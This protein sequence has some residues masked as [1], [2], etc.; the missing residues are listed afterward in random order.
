MLNR[1]YTA[2]CIVLAAQV[3]GQTDTT[4]VVQ[5]SVV[6]DTAN[7]VTTD[8][9]IT[10]TSAL[11]LLFEKLYLLENEKS[12]QVNIV[13]IGD[14]HIQAD[15]F[16]GMIRKN[17][18]EK[19]GNGGIG[20]SFPHTLAKTNGSYAVKYTSNTA[21]D[22]RRNIY[23]PEDGV[24]VGLSGI[25]LQTKQDF[26]I[27]VNVRDTANSFNTIKIISPDYSGFDLATTSKPIAIE[28]S[29]PKK[30]SHTIKRGEVLGTIAR[31]YGVTVAQIKNANGLRSDNIRAGQTLS[32][33]TGQMEKK[34]VQRSEFI[35]FPLEK[36]SLADYYVSTQPLS[37][38][39]ILPNRDYKNYSLNG[40]VLEKDKPG[41]LYHSIGVN[42]A[43]ASDY[44]KYPLFFKQLKAL[45]PDLIVISLGTNE[46]FDKMVVQDYMVQLNLFLDNIRQQNPDACVLVMTPPPSLFN[47]KYPNTFV[48]EYAK[49]IQM[50]ETERLYA[51]WDLFSEMGGLFN[52][53]K[54]AANGLM[55]ADKVH[56]SV[57]GYEKQG[58]LFY[59]AFIKA[60]ENFKT[61][62]E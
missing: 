28:S 14:S 8:N 56:Y 50:Q 57:Q 21:W 39:Y 23:A 40:L 38:I 29:V 32:I 34:Q 49:H 1:L 26:V 22:S 55:S 46:S 19:F 6:I 35:P 12:G 62:R 11:E 36:D 7:V 25:G 2:L 37:K 3:Y 18:Q 61:G 16:S 53:N 44:N 24:D 60:Y 51:S 9:I 15:L 17:L 52:V 43:K 48:A 10:N 47:R 58:Q 4:G 31:K 45:Q 13:H 59:E 27:E 54:N 5:D 33:P 42:G 20:F 30:I 41:L